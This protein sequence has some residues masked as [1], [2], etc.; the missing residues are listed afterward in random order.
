[1]NVKFDGNPI[2]LVGECV[3]V[4]DNAPDFLVVDNGLNNVKLSNTSGKRIFL[5]IPSIDT[6]VCDMEVRKFNEEAAKLK[7]VTVYVVSM[8]LPFAQSRWCGNA[9]VENVKIVSDYKQKSFGNNY[10]TLV[11]ELGLLSRAVFVVDENNKVKYVEYC[12]DIV[13]EPNYEKALEAVK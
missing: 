5:A 2:T 7:N 6:P 11:E 12:E 9:G 3:N 4:G 1:M 8:D 13:N 10:G